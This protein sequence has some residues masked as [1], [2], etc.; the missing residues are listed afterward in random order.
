ML[1]QMSLPFKR[2][3]TDAIASDRVQDGRATKSKSKKMPT[4]KHIDEGGVSRPSSLTGRQSE[5]TSLAV[6]MCEALLGMPGLPEETK[7]QLLS[8]MALVKGANDA[9]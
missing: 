3:L 2:A 7:A 6:L 1:T 8:H 9:R 5:L 4:K